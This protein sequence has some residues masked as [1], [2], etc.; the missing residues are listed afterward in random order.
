M[1]SDAFPTGLQLELL[2]LGC[3]VG[4]R[5]RESRGTCCHSRRPGV[6]GMA[7]GRSA[8]VGSPTR[9]PAPG[10]WLPRRPAERQK[11]ANPRGTKRAES[12]QSVSILS[13]CARGAA[14]IGDLLARNSLLSD[15]RPGA[16][17]RGA[18][19]RPCQGA[20]APRLP[21][22]S[23]PFPQEGGH[24]DTRKPPPK[25]RGR[26]CLKTRVQP[27][28]NLPWPYSF[29]LCTPPRPAHRA[30]TLFSLPHESGQLHAPRDQGGGCPARVRMSPASR[31]VGS[32]RRAHTGRW[33]LW[34][35][36]GPGTVSSGQGRNG[37]RWR[38]VGG[39]WRGWRSRAPE[40][41]TS[42]QPGPARPIEISKKA[43][44]RGLV[45][46]CVFGFFSGS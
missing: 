22:P 39:W 11:H 42:P 15:L 21:P 28:V 26:G 3:G 17:S 27:I 32:R 37:A 34:R 18:S 13:N 23:P 16:D 45:C 35:P 20:L 2:L 9:A 43:R 36:G 19:V 25:P 1:G 8:R 38:G 7:S 40:E 30:H 31:N 14:S 5:G 10:A 46:A 33:A 12:L 6:T 29:S 41:T 44:V 4:G 24:R